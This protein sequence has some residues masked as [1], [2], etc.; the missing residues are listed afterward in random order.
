[1]I[2]RHIRG[3]I[4]I[5]E[6]K[7][8]CKACKPLGAISSGQA[9]C[10]LLIGSSVALGLRCGQEMDGVP[11]EHEGER[12]RAIQAVAELYRDFLKEFHRTDCKTLSHCDF[13]DS[14]NLQQWVQDK[15]C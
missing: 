8:L 10:G 11:E 2:L 13:S 9:T 6:L 4:V 1:L 5:L 3:C 12:N 14:K 7:P 15:G